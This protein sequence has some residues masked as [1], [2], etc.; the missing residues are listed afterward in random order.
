MSC[1]QDDLLHEATHAAHLL[2]KLG[3]KLFATSD[4]SAFLSARG[5]ENT[6]LPWPASLSVDA[7]SA[8]ALLSTIKDGTVDLVINVAS[9]SKSSQPGMVFAIHCP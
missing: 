6:L 3:F 1:L 7:L 8:S 5:I 4:T 9:P 2:S